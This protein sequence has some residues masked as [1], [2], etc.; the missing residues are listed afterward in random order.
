MESLPRWI[1][2]VPGHVLW[3]R[4]DTTLI[5]QASVNYPGGLGD[6][7]VTNECRLGKDIWKKDQ[8]DFNSLNF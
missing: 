8:S 7:Q 6:Y 3:H 4:V 2:L 5:F 1:V